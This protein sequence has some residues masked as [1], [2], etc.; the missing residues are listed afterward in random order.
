MAKESPAT[1]PV[2]A[3]SADARR[4]AKTP[5]EYMLAV[6]MDSQV[7]AARRDRMAIAAAPFMHARKAESGTKKADAAARAKKAAVGRFAAPPP[8]KLVVNNGQK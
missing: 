5:L 7:D 3:S 1:P 4:D 2:G 8:P 6:M